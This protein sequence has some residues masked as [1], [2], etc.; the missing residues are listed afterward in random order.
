[1]SLTRPV[2]AFAL[3][4]TIA[5]CGS[6]GHRASP[7]TTVA[8]SST[9]FVS[10]LKPGPYGFL[11]P[12]TWNIEATA[13]GAKLTNPAGPGTIEYRVLPGETNFATTEGCE[14]TTSRATRA[15]RTVFTCV[16]RPDGQQV[17]GVAIKTRSGMK[18]LTITLPASKRDVAMS[19]AASFRI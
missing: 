9:T 17:N 7:T 4:L 6:S 11:V 1:M 13:E 2:C 19:I 14:A 12:R 10:P 5:A 3:L 15:D 18:V 16:P 8:Q